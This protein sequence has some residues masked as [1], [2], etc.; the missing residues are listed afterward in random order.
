MSLSGFKVSFFWARFSSEYLQ[1]VRDGKLSDLAK[2]TD[3]NKNERIQ[4][5]HSQ[6]QSLLDPNE[7]DLFL[8]EF[9]S[10]VR[11]V[12]E[13]YANVSYLR[14]HENTAI[15]RDLDNNNDVKDTHSGT[16]DNSNDE[17]ET[18]SETD[19]ELNSDSDDRLSERD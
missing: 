6:P 9:V 12:T 11:C 2:L 13:G 17:N 7:R 5:C 1:T 16:S 19:G 15:Y 18:Y 8:G 4:L 14:R 10:I 3:F